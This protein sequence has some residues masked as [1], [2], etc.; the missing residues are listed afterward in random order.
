MKILIV[1]PDSNIAGHAYEG[2]SGIDL[3]AASDPLILG[4]RLGN[5]YW[6]YIDYIE[7]D[8]NVRIQPQ[9]TDPSPLPLTLLFPRSSVSRHH[10]VLANS[11]GVIDGGYTDTIKVRF[12]Y[13][14]QP[15]DYRVHKEKWLMLEPNI[16]RIYKKGDKIAQLIFFSALSP[17][18]ELVDH[19]PE[20]H[21]ST[22]GF[23]SSGD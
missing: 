16:D 12:K 8:T 21:R 5:N 23:G 7:Y 18:L 15:D 19:L 13:I 10:L 17:S 1:D 6:K 14:P 20:T 11:V 2:D 3:K 4:F 22:G 9:S